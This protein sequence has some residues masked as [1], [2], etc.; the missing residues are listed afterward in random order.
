[1]KH[2]NGS[3]DWSRTEEYAASASTGALWAGILDIQKTL[4]PARELDRVVP[5]PSGVS[6]EGVYCD[7]ISVYRRELRKRGLG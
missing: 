5:R 6:R 3:L 2:E 4:L 1:M 7:E